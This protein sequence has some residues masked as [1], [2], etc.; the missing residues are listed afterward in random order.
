MNTPTLLEKPVAR[1]DFINSPRWLVAESSW[2][3]SISHRRA[4]SQP[5]WKQGPPPR[6]P[7]SRPKT[8][9]F[10]YAERRHHDHLEA[11]EIGQGIKTSPP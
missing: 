3:L 2:L 9:L 8:L 4:L 10:A 6:R 5:K 1:R 11:A 7:I